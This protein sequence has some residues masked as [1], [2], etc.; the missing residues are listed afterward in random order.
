MEIRSLL[1]RSITE[2]TNR[3]PDSLHSLK[4][5]IISIRSRSKGSLIIGRLVNGAGL[6]ILL[7]PNFWQMLQLLTKV[8]IA[9]LIPGK[10]KIGNSIEGFVYS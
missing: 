10:K 3:L 1:Q 2:R 4:G 8:L 6:G 7:F 5:T 9:T